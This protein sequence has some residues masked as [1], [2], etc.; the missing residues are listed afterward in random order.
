VV[1]AQPHLGPEKEAV[2]FGWG[3]TE[4]IIT[5]PEEDAGV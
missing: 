1:G 3:F 4:L 5:T 2:Q